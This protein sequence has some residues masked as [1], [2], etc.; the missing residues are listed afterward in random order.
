MFSSPGLSS[1]FYFCFVVVVFFGIIQ[2]FMV[3]TSF[4]EAVVHVSL[5]PLELFDE[6]YARS[7]KF[8]VL[9]FIQVLLT[10]EHCCRISEFV[11]LPCCLPF[12]NGT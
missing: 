12:S 2:V 5:K 3:I 4:I 10:G 6:V 1:S 9:E 7:F 11:G 8:C